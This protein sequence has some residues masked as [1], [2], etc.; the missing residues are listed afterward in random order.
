MLT[1]R[2]VLRVSRKFRKR[3]S[4]SDKQEHCQLIQ[5]CWTTTER[6]AQQ[7]DGQT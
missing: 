1:Q 2:Y 4:E 6:A 7:N 3:Q 5:I